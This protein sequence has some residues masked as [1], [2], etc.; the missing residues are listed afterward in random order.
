ME[1]RDPLQRHAFYKRLLK[2][3]KFE[4]ALVAPF[5]IDAHK[6]IVYYKCWVYYNSLGYVPRRQFNLEWITI[7][8]S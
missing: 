5:E 6:D 7:K 8:Q 3:R 1:T 2:K 4:L